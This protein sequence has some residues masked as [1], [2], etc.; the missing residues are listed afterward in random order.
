MVNSSLENDISEIKKKE[1]TYID[2]QFQ[3]KSNENN[4]NTLFPIMLHRVKIEN[5][6]IGITLSTTKQSYRI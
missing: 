5:R 4:N 2:S 6:K 1:R 3:W